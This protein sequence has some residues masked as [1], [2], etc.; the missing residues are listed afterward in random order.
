MLFQCQAFQ[1]IW[2]YYIFIYICHT[3]VQNKKY[4]SFFAK[5]FKNY[6]CAENRWQYCLKWGWWWK[7]TIKKF[8]GCLSHKIMQNLTNM[9]NS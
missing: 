3:Y 6:K 7:Q 1:N 2:K 8:I 5:H 4:S 9:E